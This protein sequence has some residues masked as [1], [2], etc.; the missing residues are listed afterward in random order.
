MYRSLGSYK[1]L[2]FLIFFIIDVVIYEAAKTVDVFAALCYNKF[3]CS[4][5][6]YYSF[7]HIA[8]K[9]TE[10]EKYLKSIDA[11]RKTAK[12]TTKT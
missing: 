8:G 10:A 3:N 12:T 1:N 7:S 9:T 2:K 6:Y 5:G 4:K 11:I